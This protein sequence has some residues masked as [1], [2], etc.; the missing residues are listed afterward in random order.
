MEEETLWKTIPLSGS[1]AP[2]QSDAGVE[3][4]LDEDQLG[5]RWVF[6]EPAWRDDFFLLE[7]ETDE[8]VLHVNADLIYEEELPLDRVA[9]LDD[10]GDVIELVD[11]TGCIV[12]TA[13]AGDLERGGWI[14]GTLWP[15]A[16]MER[17]DPFELDLDENWH[18]NLGLVRTEMD[19]WGNLIHGTPKREN[20]PI[21]SDAVAAQGFEATRHPMGEPI[22]L[23]F[24]PL[25]EW[26]IG[27]RLWHV[28]VTTPALDEV[29]MAEWT[30]ERADDG[31]TIVRI[32]SN[33]LPITLVH[34]WVRTPSGDLLF[35]PVELYP[36]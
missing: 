30:V 13:S 32:A 8:A 14:A 3:F 34:M 29:Q 22:E 11:P 9:D 6:W 1:I 12:D 15:P 27:E 4:R 33:Q 35:A 23:R 7:R 5:T 16:T 2:Y 17:T 10:R 19:A 21:L 28:V 31:D 20:S 24:D 36:Y 26:P 25:P 18:T